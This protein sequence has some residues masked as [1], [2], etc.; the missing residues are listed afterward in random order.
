MRSRENIEMHN[1][2]LLMYVVN[3][4]YALLKVKRLCCDLPENMVLYT[5]L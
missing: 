4:T 5:I 3:S 2:V 1:D